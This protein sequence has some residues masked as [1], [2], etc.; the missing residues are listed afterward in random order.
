MFTN[1]EHNYTMYAAY[2]I[3]YNTNYLTKYKEHY[4]T[5][6]CYLL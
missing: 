4:F 5:D 1:K 6:F 3:A 2:I